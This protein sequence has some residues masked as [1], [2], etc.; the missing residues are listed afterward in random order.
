[1]TSMAKCFDDPY[2]D[3]CEAVAVGLQRVLQYGVQR[4]GGI[5]ASWSATNAWEWTVD[6]NPANSPAVRNVARR[7]TGYPSKR[8]T[9]SSSGNPRTTGR[10]APTGCTKPTHANMTVRVGQR[11][12][13]GPI[14]VPSLDEGADRGEQEVAD[15]RGVVVQDGPGAVEQPR[16]FAQRPE[17]PGVPPGDVP[18]HLD[19]PVLVPVV[20]PA[21]GPVDRELPGDQEAAP[22]VRDLLVEDLVDLQVVLALAAVG[23]TGAE[24]APGGEQR[25]RQVVVDVRV[26]PGRGRRQRGNLGV[27]QAGGQHRPGPWRVLVAHPPPHHRV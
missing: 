24:L 12:R 13:T 17:P 21:V 7:P 11:R 10:Q 6:V 14:F 3:G 27:V 16:V 8:A 9:A 5:V 22:Q 18:P 23:G 26:D 2:L 1:M 19:E 25:E 4:F 15:Q 20:E